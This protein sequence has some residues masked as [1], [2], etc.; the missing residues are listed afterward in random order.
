MSFNRNIVASFI[1]NTWTA[2][3]QIAFIPLYIRILGI[4]AYGLMGVYAFLQVSLSFLDLGLTPA[5]SR[6]M[7][8]FRAGAHSVDEIRTLLRSVE[9]VF[10]VVALLLSIAVVLVAP[11]LAESWLKTDTLPISTAIQALYLMGALI[12]LRWL[13]GLYR[14]AITGLQDLVWLNATSAAF[15]TL[16]AAGVVPILTWVSP[17]IV[18]FFLY[19][20]GITLMELVVLF[21]RLWR[22][23]PSRKT[24]YFSA[25]AL[26]KIWRFSA[27]VALIGMLY[28]VLNQADKV[29]LSTMLPLNAFGYYALASSVAGSLSL[30][31]VPI[32]SVA[33]PRL[34]ELAARADQAALG[35]AYHHFAQL[36]TLAIAPSALVLA[37]FSDHI[38]LLWIGD[39]TTA[40]E[41]APLVTLL[42]IGGMLNAFMSSPYML[43]TALGRTRLIIAF[44][45][46]YVLAFVP[47][48]Y[49]GVTAYGAIA[50]AYAWVAINASGMVFAI[51]LMHR[52]A[53]PRETWRWYVNDIALPAGAALGVAYVVRLVAPAP[54][55]HENW[56][57]AI[58]VS[59][60]LL[61]AYSA[62][63]SISPVGRQ[64]LA[65][66]W[67]Y[68]ARSPA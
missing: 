14:G 37:L 6:E 32:G 64:M 12:G 41:T 5:V 56:T 50:A 51:P 33:Y 48:V 60:A 10:L 22:L 42:A 61:L 47:A 13:G 20:A 4:E 9:V 40:A 62:A 27:G 45:C 26:R 46:G 55:L 29:L 2:V 67:S 66:G 18:A 59:A 49:F 1:G 34:N 53:L 36:L 44:S 7:A 17:T 68:L 15:A 3:V 38:L 43:Q 63:L 52:N 28:Q 58:V 23:V 30:L 35:E 31:V 8:R 11:W 57:L 21:R 19:Q 39:A 16:R 25:I 54:V 65:Q 24:P